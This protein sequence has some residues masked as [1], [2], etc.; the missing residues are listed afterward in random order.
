[1]TTKPKA[2]KFRIRRSASAVQ[3]TGA[4]DET[5]AV[6]QGTSQRLNPLE[7]VAQDGT[8]DGFP[9]EGFATAGNPSSVPSLYLIHL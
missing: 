6:A 2:K 8:E 9:A 5:P 7:Q 4:G 3:A 1:M